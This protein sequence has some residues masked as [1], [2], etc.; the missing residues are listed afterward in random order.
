MMPISVRVGL[1]AVCGA[2][3]GREAVF[4]TKSAAGADQGNMN[5][6]PSITPFTTYRSPEIDCLEAIS[7]QFFDCDSSIAT[8][9]RATGRGTGNTGVVQIDPE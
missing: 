8:G 4:V 5:V 2:S 6:T 1:F 9:R 7:V 3:F